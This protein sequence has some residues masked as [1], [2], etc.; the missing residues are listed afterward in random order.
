MKK[1]LIAIC[2]AGAL[3]LLWAGYAVFQL[4]NAL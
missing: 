3:A 1:L 4:V 2:A